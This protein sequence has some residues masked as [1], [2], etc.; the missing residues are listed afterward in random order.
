ML[1]LPRVLSSKLD[2][3]TIAFAFSPRPRVYVTVIWKVFSVDMDT[4]KALY[5]IDMNSVKG[6]MPCKVK[7]GPPVDFETFKRK[8]S[9]RAAK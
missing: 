5:S 7:G 8:V 3:P 4:K 1:E 6:L 2:L 9:A